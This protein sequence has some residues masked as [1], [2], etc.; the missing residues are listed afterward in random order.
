M[1]AMLSVAGECDVVYLWCVI[2]FVCDHDLSSFF[3][4]KIFKLPR[5]N[6]K[7]A[8]PPTQY[9]QFAVKR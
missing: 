5:V 6:G 3:F 7:S 9:R 1:S 2:M 4:R 8:D